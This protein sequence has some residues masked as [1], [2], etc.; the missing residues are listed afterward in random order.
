[1][2]FQKDIKKLLLPRAMKARAERVR[3]TRIFVLIVVV[4]R[5]LGLAPVCGVLYKKIVLIQRLEVSRKTRKM[6]CICHRHGQLE[7][8]K[9][10]S[11]LPSFF[12]GHTDKE[13]IGGSSER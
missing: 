12:I 2:T 5:S 1:M 4:C 8:R 13:S 10:V 11:V 6:T 9:A 7:E 3:A